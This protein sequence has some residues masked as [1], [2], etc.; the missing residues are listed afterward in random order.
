MRVVFLPKPRIDDMFVCGLRD[1]RPWLSR[2]FLLLDVLRSAF[3]KL[4]NSIPSSF[5][6]CACTKL[7]PTPGALLNYCLVVRFNEDGDGVSHLE[8]DS[9]SRRVIVPVFLSAACIH[10]TRTT[11]RQQ[12]TYVCLHGPKH[13]ILLCQVGNKYSCLDPDN[14]YLH[15]TSHR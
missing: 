11:T 4:I 9:C 12:H 10:N 15:T 6:T 2:A 3:S 7:Q 13:N 8:E 1:A 14:S 5:L